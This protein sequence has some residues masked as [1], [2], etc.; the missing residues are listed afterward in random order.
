MD[1]IS[2]NSYEFAYRRRL[3]RRAPEPNKLDILK[4]S[5]KTVT[6]EYCQESSI[7]GLKHLV[8]ESTPF[9]E[10]YVHA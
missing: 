7:C 3:R 6:K 9:I 4:A 8:D 5:I 1:K 10:R 2:Q